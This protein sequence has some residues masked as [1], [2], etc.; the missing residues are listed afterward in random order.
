MHI[1]LN[2]RLN[3]IKYAHFFFAIFIA[4]LIT[5]YNSSNPGDK[6]FTTLFYAS[7]IV[8]LAALPLYLWLASPSRD[9]IPLLAIHSAF[10]GLTYGIVAFMEPGKMF[11]LN[12]TNEEQR[13]TALLYTLYGLLFLFSGYFLGTKSNIKLNILKLWRLRVKPSAYNQNLLYFFPILVVL[14]VFV[15]ICHL[16]ELTQSLDAFYTYFVVLCV[17]SAFAGILNPAGQKLV[18][19]FLIPYQIIFG[20][21]L[22]SS[23][24][25][26]FILWVILIGLCFITARQ[27]IPYISLALALVFFLTLQPIKTQ[28]RSL[29][30][31]TD[32]AAESPL[33]KLS[34]FVST[35]VDYYLGNSLSQDDQLEA[36]RMSTFDRLN[37]LNTFAAVIADTPA[38]QPFIYGDSY[39]SLLVKF[40]PRFFW[41]DKPVET[42]GNVWAQRYGYLDANDRTTSFN[43]PWNPEMYMNFGLA[44]VLLINMLVGFILSLLS[45]NLCRQAYDPSCFAFSLVI[46][47][48]L[49]FVENNLTLL[50]GDLII[51]AVALL[52]I[53]RVLVPL[54]PKTF[55]LE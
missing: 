11:G 36:V 40:V 32:L 49:F 10:Y 44:G 8:A 53:S 51:S 48:P 1:R 33:N 35:G 34:L 22:A 7:T 27:R 46:V 15:E 47:S 6:P 14:K 50:F 30:W 12:W 31:N 45:K 28:Y 9:A 17:L 4:L 41:P 21:N 5:W 55:Y 13:Q 18:F 26:G 3:K 54:F 42:L 24:T 2:N 20:S 43:L 25:Y 19:F 52:L 39:L 37:N 38:R 23:L 29:T 16:S